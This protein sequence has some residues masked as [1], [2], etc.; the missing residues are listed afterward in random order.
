MCFWKYT[1]FPLDV[2]V[3]EG[4]IQFNQNDLKNQIILSKVG[5]PTQTVQ[6]FKYKTTISI[7]ISRNNLEH[8]K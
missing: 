3:D 6:H 7:S 2:K 1:I 5:F 4:Q 8:K